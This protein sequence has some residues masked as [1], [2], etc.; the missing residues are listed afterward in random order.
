MARMPFQTESKE[1][2]M[3]EIAYP[4]TRLTVANVHTI[5][6]SLRQQLAQ[7]LPLLKETVRLLEHHFNTC[8]V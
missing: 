4:G 6:K 7:C 3:D 2:A 5:G 1:T 8:L